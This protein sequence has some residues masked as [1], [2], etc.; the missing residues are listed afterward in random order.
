[1]TLAG[2]FGEEGMQKGIEK[3]TQAGKKEALAESVLKLL[4]KKF[5]ILPRD[6]KEK[7]ENLDL[8]ILELLF[9]DALD[10]TN[11]DE[12]NKYFEK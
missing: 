10:F 5:G 2:I 6:I 12:I 11:I 4:T 3:G 7:I 8:L 1:M 9:D